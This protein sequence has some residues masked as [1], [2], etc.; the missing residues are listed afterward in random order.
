MANDN[1]L[2]LIILIVV[3]LFWIFNINTTEKFENNI[4]TYRDD[5]R[6]KSQNLEQN[7]SNSIL[8]KSNHSTRSNHSNHSNDNDL[9][10]YLY[11]QL[12]NKKSSKIDNKLYA[13]GIET[14]PS[15][16]LFT[17]PPIQQ[18]YTGTNQSYKNMSNQL[19]PNQQ[20]EMYSEKI[21]GPA[22]DANSYFDFKNESYM[23]IQKNSIPD[24]KFTKVM[25][26]DAKPAL[27]SSDLLP[28][29]KN[30]SW[31][32]VPN[33]KFNLLQAV[34]LEIPEIKIGID[35]VGQSRKNA[36]YDIR[37]APPNPKFVVSPWSNSTIEPDYNTKPLC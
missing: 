26:P 9:V 36:T 10:N 17:T 6:Q 15:Q 1:N 33:D 28:K 21:T 23:L 4:E 12:D 25:P 8:L 27:M 16:K 30:D 2:L 32:Q 35:T 29:N 14:N 31:F 7:R 34:D 13:N 11:N 19:V 20:Q 37:T 22:G 24:E 18:D 3:V 5:S